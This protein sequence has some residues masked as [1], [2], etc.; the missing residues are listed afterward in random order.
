LVIDLLAWP[1]GSNHLS[2][3]F[4][5]AMKTGDDC[6]RLNLG[7]GRFKKDGYVNI[8]ISPLCAPDVVHDL[9]QT[10][11]PFPERH[12]D[13]IEADHVLEHLEDPFAVMAELHRL[14]KPGG[15]LVV[16][17]PHFSRAM[18]HAQ[19]RHGFDVTFPQ[20]FDPTF[21]GGYTG[22]TFTCTLNRLRW[23]SQKELMRAIL[24]GYIYWSLLLIGT[25]VDLPANLCPMLCSR[26]W[27]FWVGGFYEVE[28]Q[29]GKPR[30]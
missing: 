22:V 14:L 12:F 7:C 4:V 29:F 11:Y 19:H 30:P 8:D 23:F 15:N 24:P 18:S 26:V 21:P 9:N 28:F 16:R 20:Y 13:L 3:G 25:A 1:A 6:A 5:L 2:K 27:C 10:P 17:V